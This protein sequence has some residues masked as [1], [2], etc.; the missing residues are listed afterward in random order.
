VAVADA[1]DAM[2]TERPYRN[3]RSAHAAI[4]ELRHV[5]GTQLDP[6]AVEA[7][8]AA[9]PGAAGLPLSA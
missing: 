5:A 2:T 4:A 9:Y 8:V 1:F 6:L 7:F 3:S